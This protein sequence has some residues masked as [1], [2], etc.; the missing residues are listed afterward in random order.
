[1]NLKEQHL[2]ELDELEK[3]QASATSVPNSM[4][5]YRKIDRLDL[6]NEGVLYPESWQFAYRCPTVKEVANFSTVIES[7]QPAIIQVTEDLI[8]K[9]VIIFDTATQSMVPT[10]E[11]CDA[12][13]LF[14]LL[15]IRGFYLPES[16]IKIKTTCSTCK[17]QFEAVLTPDKLRFEP[18]KEKLIQA[19]DGRCF[20]LNMDGVTVKFRIPTIDTASKIFKYIVKAYRNQSQSETDNTAYDKQFLLFAPYLFETG[21]ETIRELIYKYNKI[22][23]DEKIFKSY[24]TI[25]SNLKLEN[26]EY[27]ESECTECNSNEEATVSFPG[28]Y[29]QLFV[30]KT[31]TFGYF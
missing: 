3:T 10:G 18:L 21:K 1:M 12:H 28:G 2:E 16:P 25:I 5:G 9:C 7:D 26:S 8:R 17:S 11:I 6:P 19:Y 27:F 4:D 31:D 30:S 22:V 15:K 29:R 24:L 13:R 20:E 23:K 14:F